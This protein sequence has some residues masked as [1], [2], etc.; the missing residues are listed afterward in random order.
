M[1]AYLYDNSDRDQREAHD[2]GTEVSVEQLRELG[3]EYQFIGGSLEEK[4]A[5]VDELCQRREYK[6]RDEIN[7][8]PALVPD[9]TSKMRVFFTEHIHEDEEIR[10]VVEGAGFFDVR[11][12]KDR[13]VRIRVEVGDLLIVPAGIYHRFSL[14]TSDRIR[15][16]RLFKEE[17]KW[18]PLNRPDADTN[19]YRLEYL[20]L[21][22]VAT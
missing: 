2:S 6:N 5:A 21:I 10:F 16:M 19:Q 22:G 18:T 4:L 14:D 11:D 13:W 8:S 7:L 9:Y 12:K 15:A 1:R 3:V 17:P 20:R